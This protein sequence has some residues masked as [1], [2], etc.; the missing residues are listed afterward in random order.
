[1]Y[2]RTGQNARID[3]RRAGERVD[4]SDTASNGVGNDATEYKRTSELENGGNLQA[5]RGGEES[6]S[7]KYDS[8]KTYS[9]RE[10]GTYDNGLPKL[11]CLA[12][13]G[14]AERVGDAANP[15]TMSATFSKEEWC[16]RIP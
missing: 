9:V 10:L 11:Q 4:V 15:S 8:H 3:L 14:S 16:P 7:D 13:Y 12:S 6:M 1:M 5:T 2:P